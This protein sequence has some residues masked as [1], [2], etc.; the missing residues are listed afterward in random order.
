MK[1]FKCLVTGHRLLILSNLKEEK[2]QSM[3]NVLYGKQSYSII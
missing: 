1:N 2:N 3:I